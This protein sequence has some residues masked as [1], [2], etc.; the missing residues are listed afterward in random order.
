[1]DL[2]TILK[3]AG[4]YGI[5]SVVVMIS[6]VLGNFVA[7]WVTQ[8]FFPMRLKK[9]A[10]RWEKEKWATE[11]LFESLSLIDFLGSSCIQSEL[12]GRAP[13][14]FSGLEETE[15]IIY[16]TVSDLHQEGR[17]IRPYLS[18]SNKAVLDGFLKESHLAADTAKEAYEHWGPQAEDDHEERAVKNA[19]NFIHSQQV[20]AVRYLGRMGLI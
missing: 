6:V 2:D 19:I 16:K 17:R 20:I 14:S 18:G 5:S 11:K 13:M 8:N 3:F 10:W 7:A 15:G 1:M 4:G 9:E 12:E